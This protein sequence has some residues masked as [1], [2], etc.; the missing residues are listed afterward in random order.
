MSNLGRRGAQEAC[1]WGQVG[2]GGFTSGAG[3]ETRAGQ[4]LAFVALFS[5]RIARGLAQVLFLLR[6]E[7]S[8]LLPQWRYCIRRENLDSD[9]V[10]LRERH[11][12]IFSLSGTL[13][14]V[15][16]RG[17]VGRVS[18]FGLTVLVSGRTQQAWELSAWS[19]PL[20]LGA[21]GQCVKAQ[22]CSE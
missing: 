15:R 8:P 11:W 19:P 6:R 13:E 4:V 14:T 12:R 18:I 16:G 20:W 7:V 2:G 5:R 1:L 3:D 22:D 21:G 10:Q 17:V 9:V